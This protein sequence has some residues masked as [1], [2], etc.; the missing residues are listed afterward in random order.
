M[1]DCYKLGSS[2]KEIYQQTGRN[3][4][5]ICCLIMKFEDSGEQEI[6]EGREPIVLQNIGEHLMLDQEATPLDLLQ[7]DTF[8]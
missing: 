3:Q 7:F 5:T 4:V 8:P 1:I 2:P 6:V